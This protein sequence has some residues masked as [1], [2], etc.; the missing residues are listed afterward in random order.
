[1]SRVPL[2]VNGTTYQYP[3][4]GENPGWGE[5]A[6]AWAVAIT[7]VMSTLL[8]TGDIT[9][10][11]FSLA[12]NQVSPTDV[13]GLA[14]DPSLVRLVYINFSIVR[15]TNTDTHIAGGQM[16]ALFD[17]S[18]PVNAKWVFTIQGPGLSGVNFTFTDAGQVQ[19]TSD[20]M[21]GTGY[22]GIM[23]FNAKTFPQ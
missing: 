18:Q 8:A 7:N 11:T 2:T 4:A 12:N 10:T 16:M 3:N 17:G 13:I 19:Y 20:N 6:T 9:N 15:T 1:M 5:D 21:A 23:K 22:S 14:F